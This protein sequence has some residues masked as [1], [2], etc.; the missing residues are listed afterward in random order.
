MHEQGLS[1]VAIDEVL[2]RKKEHDHCETLFDQLSLLKKVGFVGID[3][4]FRENS[5]AVFGGQKY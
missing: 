2:A 3:V 5:I 4:L 1:Q